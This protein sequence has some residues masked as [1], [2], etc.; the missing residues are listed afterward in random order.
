MKKPAL[1]KLAFCLFIVSIML[2]PAGRPTA[3]QSPAPITFDSVLV[4]IWPEYDQPSVLVMYHLTLAASTRLPA[5]ITLRIPAVSGGPHAVAMQDV[6]GLYNLT[7]STAVQ[8][9]WLVI[10]FNTPVPE[11]RVEYYDPTI[12][13][14]D[15]RRSFTYTWPGDYAVNAFTIQVQQ[16]ARAT[17]MAFL[18]DLGSGQVR[19]DGLTYY[20]ML[21]G[22]VN[23]GTGFNLQISYTKTDD[24]LTNPDSF[25][26]AQPVQPVDSNTTGRVTMN[27]VL[28]W[29]LGSLGLL[30][31]AAGVWWY[32]RTGQPAA[33]AARPRHASRRAP[34]AV[35]AGLPAS[36]PK[37]TVYC[38][39]CGKR[40]GA[41]DLFCRTCGTKLRL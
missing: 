39:Q 33:S 14:D 16:P 26:Q 38:S 5:D 35:D 17:D 11:I 2:F 13:R 19:S 24:S 9:D 6:A 29:A 20:N 30:L 12:T 21:A 7:Y 25:Q 23:A 28:P 36:D 34:N 31:I 37:E 8:G 15:S 4:E 40:A 1:H 10:S 22:Q 3:A 32:L 41:G 27:D 18:P